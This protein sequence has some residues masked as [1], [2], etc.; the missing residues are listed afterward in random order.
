MTALNSPQITCGSPL[1]SRG[2]AIPSRLDNPFAT[3]WIKPGAIAFRYDDGQSAPQ[4]VAMLAAQ[5]WMGA[6]VGPHGCGKSTLIESLKPALIKAG[7]QVHALA[8]RHGQRRLPRNFLSD[9]PAHSATRKQIVVDGFEQLRWFD[10]ARLK[11]YCRRTDTGLLVTSHG[12]CGIRTLIRLSPDRDLISKLVADL[13]ARVSTG[14]TARDIAASH[15]CHGSNVREI[16]FDLYDRHE[17]LRRT[18]GTGP[19]ASVID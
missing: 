12:P 15:A 14:V 1:V 3:C 2:G 7:C 19:P 9:W 10:R 18:S 11:W 17:R 13:C 16:F 6:I 8:L 4:L 5:N